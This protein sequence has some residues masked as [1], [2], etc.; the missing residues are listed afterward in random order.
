MTPEQ[1]IHEQQ[2]IIHD[3]QSAAHRGD[4]WSCLNASRGI[5]DAIHG[6]DAAADT[7]PPAP[8]P[9]CVRVRIAEGTDDESLF[10]NS[11][12]DELV[13]NAEVEP[14]VEAGQRYE[15]PWGLESETLEINHVTA[16]GP[17]SFVTYRIACDDRTARGTLPLAAFRAWGLTLVTP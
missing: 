10:C 16:G 4:M 12:F 13:D 11:C 17:V 14:P 3:L 6:S 15:T 1:M 7:V 2:K 5:A 8:C 9:E